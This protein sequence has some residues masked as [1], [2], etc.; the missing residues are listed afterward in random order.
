MNTHPALEISDLS[1]WNPDITSKH[2]FPKEHKINSQDQWG[3]KILAPGDLDILIPLNVVMASRPDIVQGAFNL[4]FTSIQWNLYSP[5]T[6][7]ENE[8]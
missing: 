1:S 4:N 6:D 8:A 7:Q 3:K 2:D 5:S